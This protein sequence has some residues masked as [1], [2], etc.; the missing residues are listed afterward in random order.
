MALCRNE[1]EIVFPGCPRDSHKASGRLP[2]YEFFCRS[3]YHVWP[4]VASYHRCLA[5][6]PAPRY[7]LKILPAK[8]SQRLKYPHHAQ[9]VRSSSSPL[10]PA[11]PVLRLSAATASDFF[12]R[13]RR[14]FRAPSSRGI[15]GRTRSVHR[16][17]TPLLLTTR[18]ATRYA[19][20]Y[21]PHR[22]RR[23]VRQPRSSPAQSPEHQP[24]RAVRR[25]TDAALLR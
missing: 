13:P 7:P 10:W 5:T 9:I 4:A 11:L 22:T 23:T 2:S 12:V 3:E 19:A 24:P 8:P 6:L 17:S 15:N 18:H 14:T 1:S 20:R 16:P 25:A 21:A